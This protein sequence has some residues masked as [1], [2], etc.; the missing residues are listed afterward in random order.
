M[1]PKS[2][3]NLKWLKVGLLWSV[4]MIGI[5]EILMPFTRSEP[6]L[7]DELWMNALIWLGVGLIFGLAVHNPFRVKSSSQE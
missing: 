2:K 7:W 6:I 3:K 1:N 5:T 4:I